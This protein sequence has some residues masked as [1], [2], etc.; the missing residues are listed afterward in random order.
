MYKD[1]DKQREA[2]RLA[3]QRQR[4]KG[5]TTESMTPEI[6]TLAVIPNLELCR[7]CGEPLPALEQ[8]RRY[9]GV[10]IN[11]WNVKNKNR[12]ERPIGSYV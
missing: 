3:K 4:Q 7:T 11:C 5:M 10:C 6:V 9:P 1:K 12:Q 8:P 2:N